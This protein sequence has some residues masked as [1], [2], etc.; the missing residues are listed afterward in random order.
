MKCEEVYALPV[1]ERDHKTRIKAEYSERYTFT[2]ISGELEG[3]V[4]GL[5]KLI[6]AGWDGKEIKRAIKIAK[7][8]GLK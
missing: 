5:V 8:G 1:S 2:G 7:R 4:T 6:A 3:C